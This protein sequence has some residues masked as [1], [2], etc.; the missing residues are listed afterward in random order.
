[1]FLILDINTRIAKTILAF[2]FVR[3]MFTMFRSSKCEVLLV[4]DLK[5]FH[6]LRLT[7]EFKTYCTILPYFGSTSSLYQ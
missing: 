2:P 5:C 6:S 1:M 4:I 3:D 7:E